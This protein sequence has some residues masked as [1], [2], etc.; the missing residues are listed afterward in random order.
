MVRFTKTS[1]QKLGAPHALVAHRRTHAIVKKEAA[2]AQDVAA[3]AINNLGEIAGLASECGSPLA[4]IA[5]VFQNGGFTNLS[6]RGGPDAA[7]FGI[8]DNSRVVG[9]SDL[10]STSVQPTLSSGKAARA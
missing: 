7:A 1:R 3:Q 6:T 4:N 10:G 9:D 2:R 8:D 5:W